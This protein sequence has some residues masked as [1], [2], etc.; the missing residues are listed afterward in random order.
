MRMPLAIALAL[1]PL[2]TLPAIAQIEVGGSAG[3]GISL[4]PPDPM[5][6]RPKPGP[7]E[8]ALESGLTVPQRAAIA[9][10]IDKDRP[11]RSGAILV[12]L[13]V[14]QTTPLR[15]LP[16]AVVKIIPAYQGY[17]YFM[18]GRSLT[19]VEPTAMQVVN[20]IN[21]EPGKKR[22][23]ARDAL[24]RAGGYTGATTAKSRP[25]TADSMNRIDTLA[26]IGSSL[27]GV[28]MEAAEL[29]PADVSEDAWV[30]G[31]CFGLFEAMARYA[32]LDQYTDGMRIMSA[33]LGRLVGAQTQGPVLFRLALDKQEDHAFQEGAAVGEADLLAWA[34]DANA[35]PANL[36]RYARRKTEAE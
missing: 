10:A 25:M 27:L 5:L 21:L 12:G 20:V 30:F 2:L 14:P 23:Q 9:L 16:P 26:N 4:G 36:T 28:Q 35:L 1:T 34:E 13:S 11:P 17:K 3:S 22:A 15:A 32:N 8:P 18:A 19:V 7:G 6:S 24:R 33:G 31:Y 29:G